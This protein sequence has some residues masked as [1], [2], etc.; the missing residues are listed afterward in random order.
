M[1]GEFPRWDGAA[2]GCS[3]EGANLIPEPSIGC[4]PGTECRFQT[5]ASV[6]LGSTTAQTWDA[7]G[8]GSVRTLL[9]TADERGGPPEAAGATVDEFALTRRVPPQELDSFRFTWR[10]S[11]ALQ[12]VEVSPFRVPVIEQRGATPPWGELQAGEPEPVW[13]TLTPA[14]RGFA[15]EL[16]AWWLGFASRSQG[17]ETIKVTGLGGQGQ[18]QFTYTFD[19]CVPVAWR[20]DA[21]QSLLC[22][23]EWSTYIRASN[24]DLTE[25][26]GA[27]LSGQIEPRVVVVDEVSAF[28]DG[29][30][31]RRLVY[32]GAFIT[33]YVFKIPQSPD[34][35]TYETVM[36][37]A[38]RLEIPS[39]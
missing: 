8:G 25:W 1:A 33:R 17:A 19:A 27:I 20:M 9:G 29:E 37:R 30:T 23:C 10:G 21:Q 6:Q 26:L 2:W 31:V 4:I 16:Y 34:G 14:S 24:D 39:N 13:V 38:S 11:S 15:N 12:S 18:E 7:F 35:P 36:F 32:H 22:R 5:H 28:G 3:R